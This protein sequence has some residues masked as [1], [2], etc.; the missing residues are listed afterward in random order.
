MVINSKT[1]LNAVIIISLS[2]A[3]CTT[4][5]PPESTNVAATHYTQK[6]SGL[7]IQMVNDQD[8]P[9]PTANSEPSQ[10]ARIY[11][12]ADRTKVLPYV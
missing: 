4:T 10:P 6:E 12:Y 5:T 11:K 8:Y 1:K 7:T 3:A 9:G 2:I